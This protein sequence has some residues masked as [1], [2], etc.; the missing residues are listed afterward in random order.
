MTMLS[1][2]VVDGFWGK[3]NVKILNK[4][5]ERNLDHSTPCQSR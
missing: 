2:V 4:F 5:Q 1:T 3:L